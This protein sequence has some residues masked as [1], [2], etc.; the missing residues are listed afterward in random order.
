MVERRVLEFLVCPVTKTGLRYDAD[1]QE[2]LS[3]RAK[4]AYPII[5]GVPLMSPDRARH[6]DHHEIKR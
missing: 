5:N 1:K 6:M 3:D 2:L 4:L